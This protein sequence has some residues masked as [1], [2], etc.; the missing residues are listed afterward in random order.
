MPLILSLETATTNC[1]VALASNG[2]IIA[3]RSINSGYSHAEK[4][5]VFIQE[6]IDQANVTLKQLSAIAVSSGPGSYTGLRIG[7]ST[8]KGL[9]Y[10]LDLPLIAIN[11]LDAMAYGMNAG[12]NELLVP[13]IDAR[14][15]EVYSAVYDHQKNRLSEPQAIV[16]DN[17]YYSTFRDKHKL[18]LGGDGAD[19]CSDLFKSDPGIKIQEGFMPQAE[20]MT[21]LAERKF[22][23][24][25]FENVALF[26]PFYLKEFVA[27]P[28]KSA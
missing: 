5:N 27:G 1:S 16:V 8:A 18:L 24:S 14:R 17:N 10:A 7:I 13:M 21:E 28:K 22:K 3:A 6:V 12:S 2:K 25:E 23:N 15:M 11:T 19:K 4:I 9:C 26:E 20:F